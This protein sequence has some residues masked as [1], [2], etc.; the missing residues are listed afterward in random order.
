MLRRH[1]LILTAAVLLVGSAATTRYTEAA[2]L[3]VLMV[4]EH[5]ENGQRVRTPVEA[6]R[7]AALS[8]AR[9]K[10]YAKLNVLPGNPVAIEQQPS[11]VVVELYRGAGTERIILCAISIRYFRDARGYWI[12]HFQ[13][14]EDMLI[15]RGRDGRWKPLDIAQGMPSLIV[16]T[17]TTLPNAEG[18]Y[19]ALEFGLTIGLV[20]IDSWDVR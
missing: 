3:P 20:Q 18:F 2:G 16:L 14:V 8:P 1:F 15:T 11:D 13:I 9:G 7:G 10:A 6:K 5:I 19:P 4:L 17:S 12:P